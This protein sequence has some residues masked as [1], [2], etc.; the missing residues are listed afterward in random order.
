ML[1]NW[2]F[3]K[4]LDVGT[5]RHPSH[6]AQ[7]P[8]TLGDGACGMTKS[9]CQGAMRRGGSEESGA[10]QPRTWLWKRRLL[11][12]LA[13][14]CLGHVLHECPRGCCPKGS[15]GSRP[16]HCLLL[17]VPSPQHPLCP[18]SRVGP[19]L[20]FELQFLLNFICTKALLYFP[21]VCFPP[22]PSASSVLSGP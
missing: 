9:V 4:Q 17:C 5:H 13:G 6:R 21:I 3:V 10:H 1:G 22:P 11:R 15:L 14:S 12:T 2:S 20:A 8:L 7:G 16:W 19:G 18:D